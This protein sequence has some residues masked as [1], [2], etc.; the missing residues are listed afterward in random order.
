MRNLGAPRLGDACPFLELPPEVRNRIY[1]YALGGHNLHVFARTGWPG[2]PARPYCHT[3]TLPGSEVI[4]QRCTFIQYAL[5]KCPGSDEETYEKSAKESFF[6]PYGERHTKCLDVGQWKYRKTP[7]RERPARLNVA[8][9][10]TCKQVYNEACLIP[11]YDNTF[12]FGSGKDLDIFINAVLLPKQR[13]AI[14]HL[15]YTLDAREAR[16]A[17]LHTRF[18]LGFEN[19]CKEEKF[20]DRKI[21]EGLQQRTVD[22]LI[23]LKSLDITLD[24]GDRWA[25]FD[26]VRDFNLLPRFLNPEIK[27]RVVVSETEKEVFYY[28]EKYLYSVDRDTAEPIQFALTRSAEDVKDEIDARN[29]LVKLR[30]AQSQASGS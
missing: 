3:E 20:R 9:L 18:A 30:Q 29:Q 19:Q 7:F 1:E 11:Y 2:W 28:E 21:L 23:G 4:Q 26:L 13:S 22:L 25:S 10:R 6:L 27:V 16:N 15:Q 14:Q 12:S 5:C 24:R 17:P 8:L